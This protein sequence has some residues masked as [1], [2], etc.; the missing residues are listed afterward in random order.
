M[1]ILSSLHR[2]P[3]A[4]VGLQNRVSGS[5]YVVGLM[6]LS[7]FTIVLSGRPLEAFTV[8]TVISSTQLC[9]AVTLDIVQTDWRQ[10]VEFAEGFIGKGA[11]SSVHGFQ[12]NVSQMQMEKEP[13]RSSSQV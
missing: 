8:Y 2:S 10:M 1:H 13:S 3:T 5:Q 6:Q 11:H 12:K 9:P 4:S 7:R